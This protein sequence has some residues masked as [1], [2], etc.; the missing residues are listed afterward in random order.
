MKIALLIGVVAV[1]LSWTPGSFAAQPKPSRP[2]TAAGRSYELTVAT[3]PA[4]AGVRLAVDGRTVV[5]GHDGVATIDLPRGVYSLR[6]L[7]QKMQRGGIRSSFFRWGDDFFSP[8]RTVALHEPTRLQVGFEQSVR[9]D[10]ALVDRA[11]KHVDDGRVTRLTLKSTI[12]SRESFRPGHSRWLIATRVTRRFDGLQQTQIQ[13]AIQRVEVDGSNVVHEAQQRFYPS[14]TRHITV[15]LLLYSARIGAHDLLFG[16]P[17]GKK[18]DLVYP[19]GRRVTFPLN[20]RKLSL[21]SLPRGTY[22][23]KIHASGYSPAVPLALSKDQVIDLRIIS[24]LDLL[25]LFLAAGIVTAFLVLVRRPHLRARLVRRLRRPIGDLRA[26][27]DS[28]APVVLLP[29]AST[30]V[31]D[32]AA[33]EPCRPAWSHTSSA[34]SASS[35]PAAQTDDREIEVQRPPARCH[36][37]HELTAENTYIRRECRTCRREDR[38]RAR[39]RRDA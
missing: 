21:H 17:M 6:L 18:V 13:Y 20:A 28:P 36:R 16:F 25:V 39:S 12:G 10:F 22:A 3:V 9:V 14:E 32:T 33:E 23:I 5:T 30:N 38:A 15:Q 11:G 1:G 26:R 7:D 8:S 24:Y 35:L 31:P 27:R 37:G 19:N 4:V 29:L 34:Y 2:T